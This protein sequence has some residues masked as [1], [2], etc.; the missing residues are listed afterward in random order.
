MRINEKNIFLI[1]GAGAIVSALSTGIVLPLFTQWTGVPASISLPLALLGLLFATYSLS[2]FHFVKQISP[3]MLLAIIL[4]N[5][6]YC[7]ISIIIIF[8]R[9]EITLWGRAYFLGEIVILG[10]LVLVE[11]TVYRRTFSSHMKE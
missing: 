8:A 11:S 7:V 2:C 10:V 1:D 5:I 3:A 4:A 6:F 9:D